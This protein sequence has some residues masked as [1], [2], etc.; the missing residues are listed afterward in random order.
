MTTYAA[1]GSRKGPSLV[2]GCDI[3][4]DVMMEVRRAVFK[5]A[6]KWGVAHVLLYPDGTMTL[7]KK[8]NDGWSQTYW[9]GSYQRH[10]CTSD[11]RED[12]YHQMGCLLG[13]TRWRQPPVASYDDA[14]D[15]SA[16]DGASDVE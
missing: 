10:F 9:V 13:D 5:A 15:K 1:R 16:L 14:V 12:L 6:W 3:P 8:W 4:I 2:V 11:L 7:V